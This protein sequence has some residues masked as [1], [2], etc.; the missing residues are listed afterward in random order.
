MRSKDGFTLIELIAVLIIIGIL[1][2]GATFG[3]SHIVRSSL[4]TEENI[5]ATLE[6]QNMT[7]LFIQLSF[8]KTVVSI[9]SDSIA[10]TLE[11]PDGTSQ[12]I[13]IEAPSDTSFTYFGSDAS[14]VVSV[15]ADVRIIR[16]N[17]LVAAAEGITKTFSTDVA[18]YR[19][20]DG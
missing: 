17:M 1:S 18:P 10:C 2:L 9:T 16:I 3:L 19:L 5:K 6:S 7:R 13:S 11:Y 8:I 4:F 20:N 14:T 12:N 15:P